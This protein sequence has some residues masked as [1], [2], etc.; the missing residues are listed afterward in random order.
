MLRN[1]DRDWLIFGIQ[2]DLR[3]LP[4]TLVAACPND[5]AILRVVGVEHP[6]LQPSL[7]ALSHDVSVD[8]VAWA[9]SG[10]EVYR[11]RVPTFARVVVERRSVLLEQGVVIGRGG[12]TVQARY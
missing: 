7:A 6:V 8:A 9:S 2:P 12:S 4:V 10:F 3:E 1:R 5:P 11:L